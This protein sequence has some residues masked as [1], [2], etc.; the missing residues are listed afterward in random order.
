MGSHRKSR[1][2]GII[3]FIA[4]ASL[5]LSGC[6]L[7]D[8][9]VPRL[10]ADDSAMLTG[11]VRSSQ[12]DDANYWF[13]YGPTVGYGASTAVQ[14]TAVNQGSN[15][16][17]RFID[18]LVPGSTY[19]YRLCSTALSTEESLPDL[20][21]ACGADHVVTT[22]VGHLS[23]HGEGTF[24][25][26]M[27]PAPTP[28]SVAFET[29]SV[30]AAAN[31]DGSMVEGDEARHAQGIQ[32]PGHVNSDYGYGTVGCL[33]VAD[34]VAVV[35]VSLVYDIGGEVNRL[36]TIQDNGPTGDRWAV[37]NWSGAACPAPSTS[38]FAGVIGGQGYPGD[39]VV[40]GG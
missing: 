34:N 29:V 36:V 18:G 40:R 3:A 23:V 12:L 10:V 26:Q 28:G 20:P 7:S 30:K 35:G 14:R 16:V 25:N 17:S 8:T 24:V 33:R 4:V 5:V 2:T 6:V 32:F 1:T 22:T 11:T 21:P 39:F 9:G 31:P 19:H 38:V 15:L 27:F 13:E 37:T